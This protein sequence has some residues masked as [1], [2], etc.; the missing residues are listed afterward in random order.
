MHHLY[1]IATYNFDNY[2]NPT[3]VSAGVFYKVGYQE[4]PELTSLFGRPPFLFNYPD[5]SFGLCGS[6]ERHFSSRKDLSLLLEIWNTDVVNAA[7]T[8]ILLGFRL[9][10]SKIYADFGLA[11][12]TSP[13]VAPFF[14]FV[15]MPFSK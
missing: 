13:F 3:N 1:G 5:G 7:N 10:G 4:F 15:W 11:V 8:G 6:F 14:S 9:A 2:Y 12:F